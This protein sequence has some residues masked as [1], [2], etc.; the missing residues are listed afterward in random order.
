MMV[1]DVLNH[2]YRGNVDTVHLVTGDGDFIPLIEE[3]HRAGK[4]VFLS[5]FS[6]GL[7]PDLPLAA[8]RF[9][10]LDNVYF[11]APPGG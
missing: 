8:D 1:I 3:V 9:Q 10:S 7:N 4:I 11:R 5:A 2:A 6:R